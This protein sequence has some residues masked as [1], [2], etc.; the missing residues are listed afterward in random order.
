MA[1][2]SPQQTPPRRP[3]HTPSSLNRLIRATLEDVFPLL[4]V[5]GEIG[6]FRPAASGHWYFVLKDASAELKVSMFRS[7]AQL[8]RIKPANGSR[9]LVRGR[10]GVYEARGEYQLVAELLEPAGLGEKLLALHR[11]REQLAGEGLLEAARKRPLPRWPRSLWVLTSAQGAALRDVLSV[12]GRRF[13]L[14]PVT[15]WPVQVQGDEA[16]PQIRHAL[17]TIA[18]LPTAQ[19]PELVLLTRGGGSQEDLWCFNDEALVR[20][21]AA[22]PMPV[23]AAIGHEIDTTLVELVADLRAAT[24][25]AAAELLTPDAQV[26]HTRLQQ[27]RS[28]AL[29]AQ[30]QLALTSA[31]RVDALRARLDRMHPDSVLQRQRQQLQQALTQL[32]GKLRDSLSQRHA[33]LQLASRSLQGTRPQQQLQRLQEALRQP[34]WQLQHGWRERHGQLLHRLQQLQ[35]RLLGLDPRSTLRNAIQV[36]G[37]LRQRLLSSLD[38]RLQQSREHL[39]G[40]RRTLHALGPQATLDRGY[41]LVFE[42]HSGVLLSRAAQISAAGAQL[43]LQ[44]A[45][46]HVNVQL[47]D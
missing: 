6:S 17:Q 29:R 33:A 46:A 7:R 39:E 13:P 44:L 5:E 37:G 42:R 36:L 19:Q 38:E 16:A 4:E 3:V 41:A 18:G 9:V 23:L 40:T 34:R 10:L 20:Q 11:L 24:P 47:Q 35:Q 28:R 26:L 21:V 22:M 30:Q 1:E 43:R 32:Q 25:S 14:L 15:L 2:W 27:L 8:C 45:D 12:I 31:L